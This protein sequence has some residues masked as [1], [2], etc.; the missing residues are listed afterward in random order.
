MEAGIPYRQFGKPMFVM[1]ENPNRT[2]AVHHPA[3]SLLLDR[4]SRFCSSP[5]NKNSSGQ[6]VKNK[7][8]I[9]RN[10]SERHVCHCGAK[11]IKCMASPSGI[12]IAANTT[13]LAITYNPQRRP[14]PML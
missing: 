14:Q 10:G 1:C 7:I 13:K 11:R 9:E 5:R 12:A 6:A 2:D 8:A 3:R 4:D